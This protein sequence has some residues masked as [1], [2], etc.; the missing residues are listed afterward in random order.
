VQYR[1]SL[2][3]PAGVAAGIAAGLA[4]THAQAG[5]VDRAACI[6]AYVAAQDARKSGALL[7]ARKQLEICADSA[8]PGMV[9]R[10]CA[11]W[12]DDVHHA[13]PSIV[14]VARDA[15]GK[16][17]LDVTATVDEQPVRIDGHP[18]V[19]DPGRHSVRVRT[20]SGEARE[21]GIVLAE[22]ERS[23]QVAFVFPAP[24]SAARSVPLV[25]WITGGLGIA[26]LGVFGAFAARGASDRA[27]F[28]CD[29]ACPSGEYAVANREFTV[30]NVALA[31]GVA[32]LGVAVVAWVIHPREPA[33][34]RLGAR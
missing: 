20:A 28:G 24:P 9:R 22:G 2:R 32:L 33:P 17:L 12:L 14:L 8:C 5:P 10:D 23:R 29:H 26:S 21:E 6:E 31:T 16:D 18:L 34:A 1:V 4:A 19:L 25:S 13:L 11:E 27:R 7:L 15:N 3:L 30:A